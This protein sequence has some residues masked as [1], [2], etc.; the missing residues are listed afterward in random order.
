[1]ESQDPQ[2]GIQIQEE[3]IL[4]NDELSGSLSSESLSESDGESTE[5]EGTAS[6]E[7]K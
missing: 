6:K 4:D 2:N 5:N 1:M 3:G 7:P